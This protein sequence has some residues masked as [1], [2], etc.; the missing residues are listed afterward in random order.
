MCLACPAFI[1]ALS[2][3]LCQ[4]IDVYCERT[5]AALDAEPL[6]AV[7]GLSMVVVAV[8]AAWLQRVR[9]NREAGGL[10][11]ACI[12]AIFVGGFGAFLFHTVAAVWTV[13]IDMMPFL[14]FML[15]ILWLTLTRFFGWRPLAAGGA[16]LAFLAVTFGAGPV[17]PRGLLPSGAYYLTPLVILSVV[18]GALALRRSPAAGLYVGASVVFAAA[19]AARQLDEPLC[20]V[21]PL[22]THFLWHLLTAVLAWL[23]L[24]AAI[25]YA[26]A[27][28][29]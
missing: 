24:R 5:S 20:G 11:W 27:R 26:P 15:L 29:V 25:L 10:I 1:N 23:L 14:V 13:W 21:F 17:L 9:P 12:V 16:V 19:I 18:A 4:T 8:A 28:A 2:T 3:S 7:T 22:G 6:N